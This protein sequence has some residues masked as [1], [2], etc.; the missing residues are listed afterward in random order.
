MRE[1]FQKR[2]SSGENAKVEIDISNYATKGDL[3]NVTSVDTKGIGKSTDLTHLK[4]NVDK[5]DIDKLKGAP[6]CLK[7]KV[8]KLDIGKVESTPVD[9]SKLSDVKRLN[10][11]N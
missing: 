8:D 2:K 11:M 7:S 10:I 9:L 4:S 1:Y 3:K 5:L 6:R